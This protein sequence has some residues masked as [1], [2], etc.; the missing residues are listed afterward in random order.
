MF[1]R[2]KV[3]TLE[4]YERRA[5]ARH[6]REGRLLSQTS[7]TA[8][9]TSSAVL[10]RAVKIASVEVETAVRASLQAYEQALFSFHRYDANGDG[11][12]SSKELVGLLESL[13]GFSKEVLGDS[14]L[15]SSILSK[16]D[17]NMDT[18]VEFD[19]FLAVYNEL[20][21]GQLLRDVASVE[22]SQALAIEEATN[23]L[24]KPVVE[25]LDRSVFLAR[26]IESDSKFYIDTDLTEAQAFRK[27]WWRISKKSQFASFLTSRGLAPPGDEARALES[28]KALLLKY[29][30]SFSQAFDYFTVLCTAEPYSFRLTDFIDF[31]KDV[32][33]LP[34][35]KPLPANARAVTP[36]T[37]PS[38]TSSA[39]FAVTPSASMSGTSSAAVD[40]AAVAA[41]AAVNSSG[42]WLAVAS[43]TPAT[44]SRVFAASN[45]EDAGDEEAAANDD[46]ALLR[47]EFLEALVRL[48][49]EEDGATLQSLDDFLSRLTFHHL[50]MECFVN[51]NA[52][53]ADRLFVEPALDVIK[54]YREE[55]A[56]IYS[57]SRGHGS[58][59]VPIESWIKMLKR[60]DMF[61]A[62]GV[63]PGFHEPE[64]RLCFM[65]SQ[66]R[67][68]D[69]IRRR[70]AYVT[71]TFCEWVE[72]LFR[73]AE[74]RALPSITAIK[75]H[76]AGF[77][78]LSDYDRHVKQRAPAPARPDADRGRPTLQSARGFSDSLPSCFETFLHLLM[79]R[80]AG[81]KGGL[82]LNGSYSK[83]IM[84]AMIPL[85]SEQWG[86]FHAQR[87]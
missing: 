71:L 62:P 11:K 4:S 72:A 38:S 83:N 48:A 82:V 41:A 35:D 45:L 7:G 70:P 76:P 56:A 31:A 29:Y 32:G 81:G 10:K 85:F 5:R 28:I 66:M 16:I 9:A 54:A 60:C 12:L 8:E 55:M 57:A 63:H 2:A 23:L 53:R 40:I 14:D 52:F 17:A 87:K 77:K 75:K 59:A 27:D 26:R 37:P 84:L 47:F 78:S 73:A 34:S 65:A 18:F 22:A 19:E 61:D 58:A 74:M 86:A 79:E 39:Y 43:F 51:R 44:L 80:G 25:L 42:K 15:M 13:G 3:P 1:R 6:A 64:A 33:I 30:P 69:E 68:I 20:K 50:P 67:V 49:L 46:N 36:V 24:G 21:S